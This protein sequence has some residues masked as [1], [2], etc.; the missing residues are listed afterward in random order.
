M[1]DVELLCGV[2]LV[3]FED[4]HKH[5]GAIENGVFC[6]GTFFNSIG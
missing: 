6:V 5:V 1:T 3:L 2:D 4:A